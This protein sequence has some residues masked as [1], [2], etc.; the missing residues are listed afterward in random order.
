MNR[1]KCRTVL[2]SDAPASDDYFDS[3]KRIA[4]AIAEIVRDEKGGRSIA[5]EGKW[6]SGK[7][8]LVNLL[9]S[10]LTENS[11]FAVIPLH[12]GAHEGDPLRRTFLETVVRELIA[13]TWVEE[14][15][16]SNRLEELAQRLEVKRTKTVPQVTPLG[17]FVG[18]SLFLVPVGLT[19]IT[20]ALREDVTIRL[21]MP[22]TKFWVEFVVGLLLSLAPL[23][24]IVIGLRRARDDSGSSS[25]EEKAAQIWSMFFNRTYSEE[26]TETAKTANPTSIEFEDTFVELMGEGLGHDPSKRALLVLDNLDRVDPEDALLTWSTLQ[27]FLRYSHFTKYEWFEQLWVLV[28]YDPRAVTLPWDAGESNSGIRSALLEKSFQ[29]RFTVAPPVLSHWHSFLIAQLGEAFPDHDSTEFHSVYQLLALTR[30]LFPQPPTI[31]ELK[32]FINQL[33][34]LHR[35]WE[36][37]FPLPYIAYYVLRTREGNLNVSADPASLIPTELD[38]NVKSILGF[39]PSEDIEKLQDAF[40]ALHFNTEAKVARQLLLQKPIIDALGRQDYGDAP[41]LVDMAENY[42][43]FWEVLEQI[44]ASNPFGDRGDLLG[45]AASTIADSKLLEQNRPEALA[46]R[47]SFCKLA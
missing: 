41:K 33:G 20:A 25:A 23:F 47:K 19:F 9:K 7:S 2:L 12:A 37:E 4:S 28:P 26:R 1:R 46:V 39:D 32:L 24:L 13:L 30:E 45:T 17:K 11:N 14:E 27:T 5:L 3:H 34:S 35:Q 40:A 21:G 29:L 8:S 18:L 38:E 22:A 31:R 42:A 43:G 44:L 15:K 6:G 10:K 36:D 16:W